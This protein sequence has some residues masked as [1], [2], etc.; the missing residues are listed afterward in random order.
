MH[1]EN[2]RLSPSSSKEKASTKKEHAVVCSNCKSITIVDHIEF[3]EILKC[4]V[5]GQ[6]LEI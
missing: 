1:K 2:G 5:C 3:G 6:P 4:A